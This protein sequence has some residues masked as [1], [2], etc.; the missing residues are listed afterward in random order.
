VI[1]VGQ[2]DSPFVRR[3]AI[4]LGHYRLA[5]EHRPWSVWAQ[6][7]E[8]AE[9]NPLRRVPV[10]VMDSGEV[11][12]ESAAIL[13][14]LDETVPAERALIARSGSSRRAVLRLCALA[15]G[16]GDK[17]VSLLYEGV[18][19]SEP[20]RSAR[21]IDRCQSQMRDTLDLLETE[22]A[23]RPGEFF[24]DAFSHADIA[25]TCALRFVRE[26]HP[27]LLEARSRPALTAHAHR[28]E[29]MELFQRVA[30]PLH[31]QLSA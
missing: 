24:L 8:I 22:R 9:L 6:A 4:A 12:I 1:L 2:Y 21:W 25:V 3:V 19:R 10:L 11:L 7:D 26:A 27:S 17:A 14:A 29:S 15:T 30:Q 18:L 5:Y 20:T 23:S 16:L 28:F 31:V 13:D